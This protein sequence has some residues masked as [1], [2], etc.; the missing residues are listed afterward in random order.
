MKRSDRVPGNWRAEQDKDL[1]DTADALAD[2]YFAGRG[3]RR[4]RKL[5]APES[6]DA[7]VAAGRKGRGDPRGREAARGDGS[8]SCSIPYNP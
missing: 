6:A 1:V 2:A 3:P 4:G 7:L 8:E 5:R